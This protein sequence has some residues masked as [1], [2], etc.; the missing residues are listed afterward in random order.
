MNGLAPVSTKARPLASL[1]VGLACDVPGVDI[2]GVA[3]DSRRVQ[4]GSLFLAYRGTQSH[5]LDH[6]D[7]AVAAGAVAV[8]WDDAQPPMLNVPSVR[9]EALASRASRIASSVSSVAV[10]MFVG[11][12]YYKD[13]N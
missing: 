9:V 11:R 10:V 6:V 5:G 1:L 3:I 12:T 8:A 2:A 7:A 4:P 13:K